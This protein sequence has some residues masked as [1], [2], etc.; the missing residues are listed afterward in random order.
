MPFAL[1]LSA[2]GVSFLMGELAIPVI[3][4]EIFI[5]PYFSLQAVCKQV[6]IHGLSIY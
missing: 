3:L 2:R 5:C 4:S 1:A 6:I